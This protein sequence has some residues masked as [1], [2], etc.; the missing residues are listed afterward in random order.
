MSL[1]QSWSKARNTAVAPIDQ[2][3]EDALVAMKDRYTKQGNLQAAIAVDA[4]I[5]RLKGGSTSAEA[6][7]TIAPPPIAVIPATTKLAV[8]TKHDLEKFMEGTTWELTKNGK[9]WDNAEFKPRGKLYYQKDRTWSATERRKIIMQGFV[10]T[11]SE[12]LTTFDVSWGETGP[13][14]GILKKKEEQK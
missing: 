14:V 7:P 4:A 9:H 8:K 2:K 12:D 1:R 10:A 6:P 11:L 13:L 3:Y 5:T